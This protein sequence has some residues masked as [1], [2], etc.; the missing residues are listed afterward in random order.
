[1]AES[2]P[3]YE[4]QRIV[5][6]EDRWAVPLY[7]KAEMA[8]GSGALPGVDRLPRWDRRGIAIPHGVAVSLATLFNQLPEAYWLAYTAATGF[9]FKA[10]VGGCGELQVLRRTKAGE[11]VLLAARAFDTAA[12]G[13][14][15]AAIELRVEAPAD[16]SAGAGILFVRIGARAGTVVVGAA[17][18][19]ALGVTPK[20]VGL[21]AGYC[22]Y[23][24]ERQVTEN[25]RSVLA[26][27]VVRRVLTRLVVVE[28]AGSTTLGPAL[29]AL[30]A[31]HGDLV[32]LIQQGNFGGA[33]GFT[34]V[35]LEALHTEGATHVL[36]MDD[37]A[38]IEPEAIF[39][40]AAF[41]ALSENVALGGQMLDLYRPNFV[42]ETGAWF[43]PAGLAI[44]GH[45]PAM[46]AA[47]GSNLA[48][49]AEV[50]HTDYNGWWFFAA[51]LDAVR[52]VGL[53]LPLF[54]HMDDIE[55][56]VRLKQRGIETVTLPGVGVWH[57]P[58]YAKRIPWQVYY[59]LRNLFV[60]TSTSGELSGAKAAGGFLDAFLKALL[61]H[62]YADAALTCLALE[63]WL[64]GIDVVRASPHERHARLFQPTGYPAV[65]KIDI[66]RTVPV[67]ANI[68]TI[69]QFLA[70]GL[71][72]TGWRLF[73]AGLLAFARGLFGRE[74]PPADGPVPSIPQIC[75]QWWRVS[76]HPMLAVR[77]LDPVVAAT[78]DTSCR[79]LVRSPGA[80]RRLLP[81]GLLLALRLWLQGGKAARRW[82]EQAP[83]VQTADFWRG[84]LGLDPVATEAK[85][86]LRR[87]A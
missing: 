10:V 19:S 44:R 1:M 33:G 30:G 56:C 70:V 11:D 9:L 43:E 12:A 4:I 67:V 15:A 39:R 14:E 59:N 32:S 20:P 83:S 63:D 23:Q 80:F 46:N 51:P 24:R 52:T 16:R 6:P 57:E 48:T 7:L 85:P 81:R 13:A 61:T 22:T 65:A 84:Y 25:L 62:N 79:L 26:D 82:R 73:R 58:F 74:R 78:G 75:E 87:A 40:A 17:G 72:P 49:F 38:R 42:H 76:G 18:W 28:Q 47:A 35:L 60:I 2:H 27:P 77:P 8:D 5:F 64:H 37:D 68:D 3:P 50:T 86:D 31:P 66:E 54:L 53:P 41:L 29:A 71:A 34:R 21:V 69:A 55:H 36:L 45:T